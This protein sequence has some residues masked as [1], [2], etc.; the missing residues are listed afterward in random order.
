MS[1]RTQIELQSLKLK[2]LFAAKAGVFLGYLKGLAVES[3]DRGM[4]YLPEP[5]VLVTSRILP[6]SWVQCYYGIAFPTEVPAL[7]SSYHAIYTQFGQQQVTIS[8]TDNSTASRHT[9]FIYPISC[10]VVQAEETHEHAGSTI[11]TKDSM[12]VSEAG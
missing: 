2:E 6:F 4:R 3:V 9:A 8:L 7:N 5:V 12:S 11:C 1:R 10:P